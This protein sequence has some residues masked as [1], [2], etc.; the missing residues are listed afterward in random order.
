MT[1]GGS[2]K[3]GG[4]FTVTA[5]VSNPVPGQTVTLTLPPEFEFVSGSAKQT[6]PPVPAGVGSRNSPVTWKVRGSSRAGSYVLKARPSTGDE[7]TYPW[8]IKVQ[9]LWDN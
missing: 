4:E 7:Q 3:P 5:Y 1:A 6:V 9:G 8:H 2:F